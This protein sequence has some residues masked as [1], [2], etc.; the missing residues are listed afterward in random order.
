MN[1]FRNVVKEMKKVSW[2][3]RK[4]LVRY[5]ITVLS[6]VAF[7]SVFFW[8]IDIGLNYLMQFIYG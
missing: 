3:T 1:F 8:V 2:P 6:T 7:V 4:E 5:T